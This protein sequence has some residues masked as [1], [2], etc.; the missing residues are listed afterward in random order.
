MGWTTITNGELLKLASEHFDVFITVDRNLAFQQNLASL[1]IPV[2]VLQAKTNRLTDLR[3]LVPDLL[4]KI[5]S[6]QP[7]VVNLIGGT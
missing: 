2:V 4:A 5:D 1:S 3:P 6:L 7:G